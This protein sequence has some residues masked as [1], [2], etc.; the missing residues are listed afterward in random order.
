MERR[1]RVFANSCFLLQQ[2]TFLINLTLNS[3]TSNIHVVPRYYDLELDQI[4]E[5]WVLL[6]ISIFKRVESRHPFT[7]NKAWILETKCGNC[8]FCP[9]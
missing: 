5:S 2:E 3:E 6:G 7:H 1:Q 8:F 9:S 4:A